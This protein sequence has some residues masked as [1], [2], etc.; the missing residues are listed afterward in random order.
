MAE[1]L[2]ACGILEQGFARIRCDDCAHEYS[3]ASARTCRYFSPT[4]LAQAPP[5]LDALGGHDTPRA[6]AAP[7]GGVQHPKEAPRRLPVPA[8]PARPDFARVEDHGNVGYPVGSDA[9][10]DPSVAQMGRPPITKVPLWWR[11][12]SAVLR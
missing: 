12:V 3:L 2:L 7:T 9:G 1:K 11:G 5:D 6:G 10:G 8:P 4:C